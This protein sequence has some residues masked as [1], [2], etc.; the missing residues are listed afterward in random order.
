MMVMHPAAAGGL[1][2]FQSHES[3][4]GAARQL[5]LDRIV[6]TYG[7]QPEIVSDRLDSRLR[8]RK[9]S[10]PLQAFL[11]ESSRDLGKITVGVKCADS[12]PW[13]L[14]VPVTVS[15]YKQVV[16]AARTLQRGTLLTDSDVTLASY[17]LA[18]LT[19]GYFEDTSRNLGMKLKR[20]LTAGEPL[21]FSIVEK[22][23]AITRG[24]QVHILVRTGA[25]EVRSTGKALDHGAVGERIGVMNLSSQ[26]KLEGIVTD[27]GEIRVDM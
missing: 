13:S 24:Q 7:E 8:L 11:P 27:D 26:Q 23:R 15:I 14:H 1:E 19:R 21:T 25:M 4:T 22:P 5:M 17:D 10:I 3:I 2:S 6:S 20:R 18:D 12:K 9:C 16:V